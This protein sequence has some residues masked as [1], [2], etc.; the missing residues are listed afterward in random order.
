[1]FFERRLGFLWLWV[2]VY[3]RRLG[4]DFFVDSGRF[5]GLGRRRSDELLFGLVV[6]RMR[7]RLCAV[8]YLR[9]V[10]FIARCCFLSGQICGET[11][12]YRIFRILRILGRII[13]L[14]CVLLA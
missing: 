11:A 8:Q 5:G 2:G 6:D 1:M 9:C 7:L 12:L 4:R 14:S 13:R 10:V 3:L